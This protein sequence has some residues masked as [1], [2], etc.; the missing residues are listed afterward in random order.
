MSGERLALSG[1]NG[2]G[3]STLLKLLARKLTEFQGTMYLPGGLRISYVPQ[4]ASFL[5]GSLK[6]FTRKR[7][8]DE[9]LF[10]AVLHRF[11]FERSQFSTDM[12]G[13][14][15]GQKKKALLAA[16]LCEEAHL[17]LWDEPLN[18]IDVI[19]RVQIENLI[20]EYQPSMVLV[21][22]DQMFLERVATETLHLSPVDG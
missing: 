20:L 22:H 21:E 9:S 2:S 10:R 12:S 13:F 1:R 6:D 19:S 5:A 11:G 8:I 7:G 4:D 18:Y 17:Y 14:S 15:A 16:S 3:K